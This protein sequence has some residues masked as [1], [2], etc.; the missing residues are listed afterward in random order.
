MEENKTQE[1][2]SESIHQ[3]HRQRMT[4]LFLRNG[5]DGF[6][7]VQ[8]LE[9]LLGYSIARIDTNPLAHRLL[10]EFGDLH[11]VFNAPIQLLTKVDGIGTRTACLL[12]FVGESWNRSEQSRYKNEIYL[13]S[14]REIGKYLLAHI[15]CYREERAFLLSLDSKCKVI[16]LREMMRGDLNTVNLPFRKVLETAL[17]CNASSVI[18]VH[19]HVNGNGVPSVEDIDYTKKLKRILSSVDLVF[20]DHYII[21]EGSYVSMSYSGMM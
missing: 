10:D 16:E 3:G 7:D 19:N 12:R 2:R 21:T 20:F 6:T 14:T 18:L 9:F 8:I 13:R 1:K 11:S 15:G 5:I 17:M 4:E